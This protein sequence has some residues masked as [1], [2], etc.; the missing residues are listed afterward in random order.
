MSR[1]IERVALDKIDVGDR[2][3]EVDPAYVD[4]LKA[5]ILANRTTA[6][7]GLLSPIEI[8]VTEDGY[9]LVAGGHRYAAI[10]AIG[11][12]TIDAMITNL[13]DL[14]ARLREID[15][16]LVRRELSALDRAGFLA[17]RKSVWETMYPETARGKKGALSRWYDANEKISFASDAAEKAG[18]SMRAVQM[19]IKIWL[20]LS[21]ESRERVRGTW[22]ADHQGQ[23]KALSKLGPDLQ[24]KV[25]D[26]LLRPNTPVANVSAAVDE[27]EGTRRV[28]KSPEDKAYDTLLSDWS[29][30]PA[31][32]KTRFLSYLRQEGFLGSILEAAE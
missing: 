9:R 32:A 4:V 2:L 6:H 1:T 15:E 11:D 19:D 8:R 28:E 27:V 18:L 22:L 24:A 12:D 21:E 13:N 26:A 7:S 23:L 10:T 17:Q 30:A 29:H 5:S 14:Q 3:R 20:N 16:N 25:L 31:K